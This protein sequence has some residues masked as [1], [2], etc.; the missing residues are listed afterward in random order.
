MNIV[1]FHQIKCLYVSL[2]SYFTFRV[3]FNFAIN[4]L[5]PRESLELYESKYYNYGVDLYSF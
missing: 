1:M 4:L 2:C 3:D 5:N